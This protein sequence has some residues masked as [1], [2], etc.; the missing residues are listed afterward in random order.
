[1]QFPTHHPPHAVRAVW[2]LVAILGGVILLAAATLAIGLYSAGWHDQGTQ[3]IVRHVP[4]PA[5]TINWQVLP[6]NDYF[7][8]LD[9]LQNYQRVQAARAPHAVPTQSETELR[10]ST[11]R[12]I[13]RDAALQKILTARNISLT[14]ADVGQAYS[15]QISQVGNRATTEKAIQELYGWGP[16]EYQHYVIRPAVGREKL[17]E[18]LSFT[19]PY[20]QAAERQANEVLKL[21]Q[22]GQESFEDLAKKYSDDVYGASGGDVGFVR[23]GQQADEIDNVAFGLEIGQVSE[24][25]H[26][27]Y[28]YHILKVTERREADKE[29]EIHLFQIFISGPSVDEFITDYLRPARISVWIPGFRWDAKT[30]DV[31]ADS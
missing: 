29:L 3:R 1:M 20:N 13:L 5:A 16:K 8:Q 24:L 4:M 21:V 25:V 14:E 22:A 31:V 23:R 17:R 11:L 7:T 27:K 2:M 9:A 28:G 6:V 26:T 30:A 10:R 18:H 15:S 19:R 12:K